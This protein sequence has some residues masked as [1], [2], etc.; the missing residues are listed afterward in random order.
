MLEQIIERIMTQHWDLTACPCW[1]CVA[2][3]AAGCRP[4]DGYPTM[5]T[6][7]FPSVRV[8]TDRIKWTIA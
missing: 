1:V 8:D 3:R 5:G 4:R 6:A 2:G 7:E